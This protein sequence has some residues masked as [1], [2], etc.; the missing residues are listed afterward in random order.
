MSCFVMKSERIA[1]LA[2]YIATVLNQTNFSLCIPEDGLHQFA[3]C[4]FP[5]EKTLFDEEKIYR[6]MYLFN[7]EA[8]RERYRV[9]PNE[10]PDFVL[11]PDFRP[12]R[13]SLPPRIWN[14]GCQWKI[15]NWTITPEHYSLLKSFDCYLY[16]TAEG[17]CLDSEFRKELKFLRDDLQSFIVFNTPEYINAKWG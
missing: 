8:Y 16:Q 6:K 14:K 9:E 4:T 2:A 11:V 1:T 10:Y 17:K 7:V 12:D 3:D 5:D 13:A 15:G